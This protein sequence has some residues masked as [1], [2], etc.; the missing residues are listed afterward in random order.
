VVQ[1]RCR[2]HLYRSSSN[3]SLNPTRMM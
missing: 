3:H 1:Q 2:G